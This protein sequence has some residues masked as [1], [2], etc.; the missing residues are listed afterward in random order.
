MSLDEVKRSPLGFEPEIPRISVAH[1]SQEFSTL[2]DV[3]R[4]R[5]AQQPHQLSHSFLQDGETDE[6]S[7]T[8]AEL[9]QRA[10]CI[11]ALLQGINATGERVLLLYPPGL[12]YIAAFF[13]CLYAG[14]VAVPAYPP[15]MN[16]SLWRLQAIAKDA[17]PVAALSTPS[18]VEKVDK[19]LDRAPELKN[20]RWI[21][22]DNIS[23]GYAKQ[24]REPR[25]DDTTLAFLQYTSGS[26]S[27]PKGCLLYTSPSPRDS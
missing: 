19:L 10:M 17:Q 7:L 20:V 5:A 9:E 25:I 23:L 26:T 24:W 1:S 18:I 8:Y 2:V 12:E 4:H 14:A 13:G 6:I 22:T 27:T 11:A 16:R 21:N 3:L 15:R